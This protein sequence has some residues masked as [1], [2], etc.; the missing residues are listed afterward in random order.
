[1]YFFSL[2]AVSGCCGE[3]FKLITHSFIVQLIFYLI[4]LISFW[5]LPDDFYNDG[6]TNVSRFVAGLFLLFQVMLLITIVHDWND[7]LRDSERYGLMMLISVLM[8]ICALVVIILMYMWFGKQ[9]PDDCSFNNT[10]IS[11][12]ILF[13]LVFTFTSVSAAA[14]DG[15][16]L[17][18]GVLAAYCAWMNFS[19]LT[20]DPSSCN[21]VGGSDSLFW[22][23]VGLVWSGISVTYSGWSAGTSTAL[24]DV[25]SSVRESDLKERLSDEE[26]G[27]VTE[28]V[29][30]VDA[31]QMCMFFVI[32]GACSMYMSM[33]LTGWAAT[34]DLNDPQTNVNYASVWV[35][36]I[37]QWATVLL[38]MWVLL[39]PTLF[40]DRFE[41][42]ETI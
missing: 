27:S 36:L 16:L 22:L 33:L 37:S 7:Q 38:Y 35:Q 17:V 40:P 4:L 1:V 26:A 41:Q 28:V 21:S 24:V 32:M 11:L 5:F 29:P 2:A 8:F 3:K 18:S 42:T 25:S 15:S 13:I 23:I 14:P 12:T 31:K 30:H 6:F 9:G 10:T 19:A 34:D 39:A 20:N